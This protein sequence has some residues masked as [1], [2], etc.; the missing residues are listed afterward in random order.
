[1]RREYV[2]RMINL[3]QS[4]YQVVRRVADERG[5]G[6]KSFSSA[7]LRIL[8]FDTVGTCCASRCATENASM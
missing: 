4:D 6:E 2:S 3:E 5:L 7:D 1:M 8:L